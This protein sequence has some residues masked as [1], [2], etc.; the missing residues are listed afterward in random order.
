M[1]YKKRFPIL[2]TYKNTEAPDE[3]YE[4]LHYCCGYDRKPKNNLLWTKIFWYIDFISISVV[5]YSQVSTDF[6]S[7]IV[8][9]YHI[10]CIHI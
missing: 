2:V 8:E 7:M 6:T 1:K 3:V 9:E 4:K 5:S 10:I